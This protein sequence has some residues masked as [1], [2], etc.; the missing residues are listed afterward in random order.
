MPIQTNDKLNTDKKYSELVYINEEGKG[1][2]KN[3][4]RLQLIFTLNDDCPNGLFQFPNQ[5][6]SLKLKKG[7]VLIFPPYWSHPYKTNEVPSKTNR[8][9][10]TPWICEKI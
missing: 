3:I 5:N 9:S 2:P 4:K 1:Q 6:L 10:I 7:S 8:F